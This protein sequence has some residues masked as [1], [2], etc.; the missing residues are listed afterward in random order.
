MGFVLDLVIDF[1]ATI[2]GDAW[3][4]RWRRRKTAEFD[5]ALRVIA[6][7]HE[8]LKDGWH[9]GEVTVHPGRLEF[10]VGYQLRDGVLAGFRKPSPPITVTVG[11]VATERQRQPDG[12]EKWS[13]NVDSQIVELTTGTA[14]LEWAVPTKKL[15]SA[16]ERLQ[17]SAVSSG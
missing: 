3:V 14:T 6:G 5:C 8:G 12:R 10:V 17:S 15:T 13:V 4:D 1:L 9:D 16:L 11:T 2:F 7:S